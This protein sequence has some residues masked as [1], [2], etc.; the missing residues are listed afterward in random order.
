MS[1]LSRLMIAVAALASLPVCS[2]PAGVIVEVQPP[3]LVVATGQV[4]T[5]NVVADIHEPVVG[6]GL[7]LTFDP[8]VVSLT[9][10]PAIGPA[11]LPAGTLDG[12]GLA[13]L[14]FPA[15]ISGT[16]ILLATMSFS[17]VALGQT[18]LALDIT[19]GDLTEGFPLD[20]TGFASV[21]LESGEVTVV[22]EPTD[23]ALLLIG[24]GLVM[25]R[26]RV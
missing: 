23:L 3:N 24:A 4:F 1:V 11:W 13:G 14:A 2:A 10:A 18:E 6:W 20:P 22:P 26:K 8:A 7:D 17:A 21:T 15:S 9:G 5:V 12:D 25:R 16:E 19:P